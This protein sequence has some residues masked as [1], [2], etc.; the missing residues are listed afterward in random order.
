MTAQ[1]S[2]ASIH[3]L[4]EA[5]FEN[6]LRGVANALENG[7]KRTDIVKALEEQGFPRAQAWELVRHVRTLRKA[8][9][10]SGGVDWAMAAR[11][12]CWLAVGLTVTIATMAAGEGG[13]VFAWGAILFGAIDMVRGLAGA[14]S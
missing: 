10:P 11:G 14:V 12:F 13:S 2:T 4:D 6:V 3:E 9:R 8:A 1:T 7:S 5:A